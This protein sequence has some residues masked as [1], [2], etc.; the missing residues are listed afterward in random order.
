MATKIL[1]DEVEEVV[2]YVQRRI[3]APTVNRGGDTLHAL[4]FHPIAGDSLAAD[5]HHHP[6]PAAAVA[7]ADMP[8]LLALRHLQFGILD[9]RTVDELAV[10]TV[11]SPACTDTPGALADSRMGA[12]PGRTGAC[13]TCGQQHHNC[14]GHQGTTG[15]LCGPRCFLWATL[16]AS[17]C[18]TRWSIRCSSRSSRPCCR[19]PACTVT[20]CV[21]RRS[22]CPRCCR[23]GRGNCDPDTTRSVVSGHQR[24]KAIG[25]LCVRQAQCP[26]A[27]LEWQ[28]RV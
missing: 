23:D 3:T 1:A 5:Q 8:E 15:P 19:P 6:A 18:R 26:C 10:V 9:A 27:G 28:R 4:L 22:T 24:I 7:S 13:Q 2:P 20:G 21:C 14:P 16:G 12:S 11:T 17:C 25:V